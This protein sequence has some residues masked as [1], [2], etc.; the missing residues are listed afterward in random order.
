[1][2]VLKIGEDCHPQDH[3]VTVDPVAKAIEHIGDI[4]DSQMVE[5]CMAVMRE[6]ERRRRPNSDFAARPLPPE[7][8]LPQRYR[9]TTE[10]ADL[11]D[12]AMA[13]EVKRKAAR[14]RALLTYLH[15]YNRQSRT[16]S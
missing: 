6:S 10:F 5:L 2:T 13:A 8:G 15:G 7:E 11:L 16:G 3:Q 4:S 1:M 9:P 12:E 14:D